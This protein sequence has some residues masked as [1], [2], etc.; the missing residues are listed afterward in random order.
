MDVPLRLGDVHDHS[1][2]GVGFNPCFR[3][4]SSETILT[5]APPAVPEGFN[6]CFRGCS[7]ETRYRRRTPG[8]V[9]GVSILVF[10]DVPLRPIAQALQEG[11]RGEVS[12][13][14][15]VDVPLRPTSGSTSG[16][17]P[18]FQSWCSWMF[19]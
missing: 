1:P 12:I 18:E 9:P 16:P 4:C 2:V 15:F 17:V 5:V 10:V 8:L 3:G 6:P 7:S 14:V 19:L 13:L 11:D